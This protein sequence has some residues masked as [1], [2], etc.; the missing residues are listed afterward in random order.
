VNMK[1]NTE[2][3][4]SPSA[5]QRWNDHNSAMNSPSIALGFGAM[6]LTGEEFGAHRRTVRWR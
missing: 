2:K 1:E 3:G 4:N 5:A 6:R